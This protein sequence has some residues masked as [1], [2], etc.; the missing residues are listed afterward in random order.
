MSENS[1]AVTAQDAQR[2]YMRAYRAK[3]AQKQRE[4]QREWHKRNPQK[5]KEYQEKF[6][7][8]RADRLQQNG[9]LM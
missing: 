1:K 3:N 8:K 9:G 7:Q 2:A 4:Y 6:W 5:K